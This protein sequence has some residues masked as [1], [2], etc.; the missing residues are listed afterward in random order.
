MDEVEQLNE[1]QND[2]LGYND[3][4][5]YAHV[6]QSMHGAML[7]LQARS[8]RYDAIRLFYD[9]VPTFA[10]LWDDEFV[11]QVMRINDGYPDVTDRFRLH[12]VELMSLL[13]RSGVIQLPDITSRPTVDWEPPKDITDIYG[14]GGVKM[15]LY[16]DDDDETDGMDADL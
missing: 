11:V 8:R 10:P 15:D 5:S 12:H 13:H 14:D 7:S 9:N 1:A 3:R 6:Y 2:V 16:G 4:I